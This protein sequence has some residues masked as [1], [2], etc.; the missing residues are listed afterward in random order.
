MR[1][2]PGKDNIIPEMIKYMGGRNTKVDTCVNDIMRS[3]QLPKEW[4]YRNNT[5]K[6]TR[7]DYDQNIEGKDSER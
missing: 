3:V 6:R 1:K 7:K 2:A 5:N 4:N